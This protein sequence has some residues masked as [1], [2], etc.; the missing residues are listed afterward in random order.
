MTETP[1]AEESDYEDKSDEEG[2]PVFKTSEK[3]PPKKT[4]KSKKERVTAPTRQQK[5]RACRQNKPKQVYD[6]DFSDADF[7]FPN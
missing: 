2:M 7:N 4:R 6:D 3:D 1:H 5:P